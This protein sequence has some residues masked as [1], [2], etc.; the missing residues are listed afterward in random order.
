MGDKTHENPQTT[1]LGSLNYVFQEPDN[2]Q[3]PDNEEN[4]DTL[5]DIHPPST[6][7]NTVSVVF[8]S[9]QDNLLLR[10]QIIQKYSSCSD[11]D[12]ILDVEQHAN[13][14]NRKRAKRGSR[15]TSKK[16]KCPCNASDATSWKPK[17]CKCNQI[18]HS[19]CCNLKGIASI[20]ELENWE[21]PWCYIPLFND[22]CKPKLVTNVL[23][24]IQIDINSIHNKCDNL[25]SLDLQNQISDLKLS[26][27]QFSSSTQNHETVNKIHDDLITSINFELEKIVSAQNLFVTNELSK[28]KQSMQTEQTHT[29]NDV[30]NPTV[31]PGKHYDH[32]QPNFLQDDCKN[33]LDSFLAENDSNFVKVS[34]REVLY[35]GEFCYKYGT[36]AHQPSPMPNTI[37]QVIDEI[38]TKFPSSP[39]INSCL[40]TKY[41]NGQSDCPSHGDDEPFIHPKS[42]IFT[43]SVGA[44]RSMQFS[45]CS[46]NAPS[47]NEV[48]NLKD[49]DILVFSRASQ[50]F[51]HHAIPVDD[52]VSEVRY[53][54]TFRT[55]APYNINYTAVI[56][57]SNTQ[58]LVFGS[59][60]GKLG[61]WLPGYRHKAS[62]INNIPDPFTIGPCRNVVLNVGLNDLQE[63]N[64]KSS[65][66]L[67]QQYDSKIK[68]VMSVYPK[69]RIHISLLLPTKNTCLNCKVNELNKGLK[70][71]ASNHRNVNVIEHHNLLDQFGFLNP[72]L[73]RYKRGLPNPND[74]VHLGPNGIKRFV[75]SIKS[76]ILHRKSLPVEGNVE[77]TQPS[78]PHPRA[79]QHSPPPFWQTVEESAGSSAPPLYPPFFPPF[80]PAPFPR[81]GWAGSFAPGPVNPPGHPASGLGIDS[82]HDRVRYHSQ[83]PPLTSDGYQA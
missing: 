22:P 32:H 40:V 72:V 35:F 1:V 9:T 33:A 17:C 70:K 49:N 64:P 37:Q 13:S 53:S 77:R 39:K 71:L 57:D 78:S 16:D 29:N 18:W 28:F 27:S 23:K 47:T 19:A 56:G 59:D 24:E 80:P 79:A 65:T 76:M 82:H 20:I 43:L 50:D 26:L 11:T 30:H 63:D 54:F 67:L 66:Y 73:G 2:E 55:L 36:T 31:F 42:D 48:I 38:H 8:P 14:L 62:K 4:P 3:N 21:C 52:N 12:P 5:C 74:H 15:S 83:F 81:P 58:E 25:N 45:N 44:K 60:K 68:A 41:I 7:S 75:K 61:Q 6:S 10:Q 34:D 69:T 51:F 46:D